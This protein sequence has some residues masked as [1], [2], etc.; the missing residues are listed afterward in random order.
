MKAVRCCDKHVHA[1]DVPVPHG[2]GV[3]VNVRSAG[4]CLPMCLR[5]MPASW[6]R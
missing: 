1:V 5:R 3:L 2:E 4:I 6:S